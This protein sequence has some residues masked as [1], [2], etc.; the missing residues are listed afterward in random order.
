MGFRV[1]FFVLILLGLS[2]ASWICG[3][4]VGMRFRNSCAIFFFKYIF[5]S[6][7]Y[8]WELKYMYIR[9]FFNL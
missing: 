1:V 4:T 2:C 6:F 3:F 7:L 8:F 5:R 9:G